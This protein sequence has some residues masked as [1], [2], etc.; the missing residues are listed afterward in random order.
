MKV[1]MRIVIIERFEL[2][3]LEIGQNAI[4][5]LDFEADKCYSDIE[6]TS[7]VRSRL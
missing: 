3:S 6:R 4:K 5:M 7:L 1:G 2:F